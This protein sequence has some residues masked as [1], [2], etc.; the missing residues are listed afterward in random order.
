MVGGVERG[1]EQRL[2]SPAIVRGRGV[3]DGF[4]VRL[5]AVEACL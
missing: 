4:G 1:P 3:Q 2:V 5:F